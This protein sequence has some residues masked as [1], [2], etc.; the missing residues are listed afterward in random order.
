[1]TKKKITQDFINIPKETIEEKGIADVIETDMHTYAKKVLEDRT[2]PHI[3]D[4]FKPVHRRILYTMYKSKYINENKTFKSARVVGD[5]MGKYHPHGDKSIYEALVNLAVPWKNNIP[6][7]H[8]EGNFGNIDGDMPAAMRY[9]EVN[10]SPKLAKFIFDDIDLVPYTPNYDNSTVEPK[11]LPV[12]L[13]FILFNGTRGIAYSIST[14]IPQYNPNEILNLM[15]DMIDKEFWH[16]GYK[17]PDVLN[18]VKG[19]D[20]ATGCEILF[21]NENKQKEFVAK[22]EVSCTTKAKLVLHEKE[23]EIEISNIPPE[24]TSKRIYD[25]IL[26]LYKNY[27]EI[28]SSKKTQRGKQDYLILK[29][30]FN[31]SK[32]D[33]AKII[34]MYNKNQDLKKELVKLLELTKRTVIKSENYKLIFMKENKELTQLTLLEYLIT[35]LN[36]RKMI[37]TKRL[38]KEVDKLNK[39]LHY[40]K[41]ILKAVMFIDFIQKLLKQSIKNKKTEKQTKKFLIDEISKKLDITKEDAEIIINLSLIRLASINLEAQEK[42]IKNLEKEIAKIEKILQSDKAIFKIIK[43][44]LEE[45]KKLFGK[46]RKSPILFKEHFA[47]KTD[48]IKDNINYYIIITKD[49]RIYKFPKDIN[50]KVQDEILYQYELTNKDYIGI[51]DKNGLYYALKIEKIDFNDYFINKYININLEDI[52]IIFNNKMDITKLYLLFIFKNGYVKLLKL[53]SLNNKGFK[54]LQL[55][56]NEIFDLRLLTEEDINEMNLMLETEDRILYF[57]IKEISVQGISANGM[58]GINTDKEI[59]NYEISKTNENLELQHRGYKG[60]IKQ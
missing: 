40:E 47:K 7:I 15:I 17:E 60:K 32:N 11:Y 8:G 53:K 34:L 27:L 5:T 28:K 4:G 50:K 20:F 45:G 33:I 10:M 49:Y 16:K 56:K 43:E 23:K 58:R 36:F 30:I 46:E 59:I 12:K 1:M 31:E 29:D 13:P 38:K 37:V 24:I 26:E 3:Y 25:T 9:T 14:N 39:K 51:I 21:D 41:I 18:F 2:I 57:P 19:P 42:V 52:K 55:T 44:E 54:G 48:K 22:K 6:L 35:F